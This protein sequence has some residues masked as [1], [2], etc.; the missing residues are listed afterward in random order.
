M[1]S[2]KAKNYKRS[3]LFSSMA[4]RK[5][6]INFQCIR[7]YIQGHIDL[8]SDNRAIASRTHEPPRLCQCIP[9]VTGTEDEDIRGDVLQLVHEPLIFYTHRQNM[10]KK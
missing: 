9:I 6:I 8:L 1:T 3:W 10:Y 7:G 5:N 2:Q 4:V